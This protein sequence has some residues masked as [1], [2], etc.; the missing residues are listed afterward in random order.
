MQT[1][2]AS[3]GHVMKGNEELVEWQPTMITV[4]GQDRGDHSPFLLEQ[5]HLHSILAIGTSQKVTRSGNGGNGK[6]K[7][8]PEAEKESRI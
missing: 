8:K 1:S 3:V 5:S 4:Y 2:K 6:L 7:R